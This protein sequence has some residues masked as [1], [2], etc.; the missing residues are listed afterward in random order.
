[1]D[2]IIANWAKFAVQNI[3]KNWDLNLTVDDITEWDTVKIVTE[4]IMEEKGLDPS[5]VEPPIEFKRICTKGC[6][7]ALEP[8]PKVYETTKELSKIG[9]II[10]ITH[11]INWTKAPFDKAEWLARYLPDIDYKIIFVEESKLKG[12]VLVDYMID[13]SPEVIKSLDIGTIGVMVER[14]WNKDFIRK[15]RTPSVKRFADIPA[16]IKELEEG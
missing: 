1:M 14:P 12:L 3:N 8:Y 9:E 10:V 13:D 7:S 5:N 6:F 15:T 4:K 11:P 2:G 16:K